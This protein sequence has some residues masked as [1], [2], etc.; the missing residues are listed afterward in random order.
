M[1]PVLTNV[2][3]DVEVLADVLDRQRDY[4]VLRRMRTMERHEP[5]GFSTAVIRG[6]CLDVETTGLDPMKDRVIELAVQSFEAD[7]NGR[8]VATGRPYGWLEDPRM[9]ISDEITRVTRLR[10][11]DLVGR[12]IHDGEAYSIL[13]S[14]DVVIAHN[15]AFDCPFV[16]R[17]IPE[18]VGSPWA[19]SLKGVDWAAEGFEGRTLSQ[20]CGAMGWFYEAHR[21]GVD[22]TALLH[23][24]DHELADGATV[25]KRLLDRE[26]RPTWLI[27]AV[28]APFDA[29]DRLRERGYRWN[30]DRAAWWREVDDDDRE[31]ELEWATLRVYNALRSPESTRIDWTIRYSRA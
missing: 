19:C 20:L 11:E 10:A 15:A 24:L 28:G 4:R 22:V 16:E 3:V 1:K 21:A 18:T 13:S 6:V 17:R 23:L 30:P 8:I 9:P 27:E 5:H 25:L 12:S 31:A 7:A 14:A 2:P 29:K 26:R